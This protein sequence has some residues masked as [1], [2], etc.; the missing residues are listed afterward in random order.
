[1]ASIP[2]F[3]ELDTV[4]AAGGGTGVAQYAVSSLQKLT[5]NGMTW[6]A[7]GAWGFY[8]ITNTNGRIFTNASQANPYRSPAFQQGGSPNI[9]L[10][11]WPYP[12]EIIGSDAIIFGIIDLSAAPNTVRLHL[13]GSLDLGT[14]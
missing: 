8:T 9:G 13:F 3:L 14:A 10:L 1:M 7:T 6:E 12:L 5:I 2:F 11:H 4:I